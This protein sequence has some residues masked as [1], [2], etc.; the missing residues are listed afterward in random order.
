[1]RRSRRRSCVC[2]A[3]APDFT[4]LAGGFLDAKLVFWSAALVNLAVVVG[5]ALAGWRAIRRREVERHRR[6]MS[7]AIV[8]VVAF[9]VA[10]AGKVLVLG[11][12]PLETWSRRDVLV[13]RIHESF[14]AVMVVAG[15][16]AR[17][18]AR[19]YREPGFR[20]D[21]HRWC[22]RTAIVA[23]VFAFVTAAMILAGMMQR[24]A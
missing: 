16:I 14:V 23:G 4:L 19:R 3:S 13:L 20:R 21:R 12:E 24:A 2:V 1:M 10:Y 7:L 6:W 15:A 8:L 18:L 22:G 9:V 17:I 11:K 5:F